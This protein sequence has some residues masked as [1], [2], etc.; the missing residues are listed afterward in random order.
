M[1]TYKRILAVILCVVMTLTAAPL[2]GFVGLDLSSMFDFKAEA[3]MYSGTCGDNVYWSLD[4]STG[5]LNISGTGAIENYT[6]SSSAP[7]SSY[8]M[9]MQ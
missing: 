2:S 1:K 8:R 6:Y 9:V 4:T 7:W 3:A 5:M